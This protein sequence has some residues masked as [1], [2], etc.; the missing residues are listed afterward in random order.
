MVLEGR[1]AAEEIDC[2]DSPD[3]LPLGDASKEEEDAEASIWR[4]SG[5]LNGFLGDIRT[6]FRPKAIERA[7]VI[8]DII[9]L[10][11]DVEEPIGRQ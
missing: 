5:E 8:L 7:D 9:E 10:A 1:S 3:R 2:E 11:L 6:L 4:R